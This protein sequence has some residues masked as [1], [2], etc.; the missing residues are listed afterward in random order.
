MEADRARRWKDLDFDGIT[1]DTAPTSSTAHLPPP[2]DLGDVR[3]CV[4]PATMP[5]FPLLE[6]ENIVT[7]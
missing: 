7:H 6:A 4:L 5:G 3:Q 1:E 2:P